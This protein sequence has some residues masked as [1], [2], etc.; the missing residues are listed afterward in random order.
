[1]NS[2]HDSRRHDLLWLTAA[3]WDDVV[4]QAAHLPEL[5]RWRDAGW[6]V[7]LRRSEPGLA[8]GMVSIGVPLPPGVNAD[9]SVARRRFGGQLTADAVARHQAPM[10]L[11]QAQG[12]APPHWQAALDALIAEHSGA[13]PLCVFGSLAMQAATSQPY[14]T[15]TSDI[16]VLLLPRTGAELQAGVAL[17]QRHC[18]HLPL[19]G[20]I[21]FPGGA[22]VSWKEWAGA[23]ASRHDRVLVKTITAVALLPMAALLATLVSA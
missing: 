17:L 12:C 22:A 8:A 19:D 15:A 14:L 16:D 18:A 1:M 20:E 4:R 3:G 21:V 9:G 2:R 11:A 13:A 7:V 6:P 5:A 10:T 23:D